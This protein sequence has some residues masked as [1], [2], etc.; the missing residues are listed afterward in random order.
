MIQS[1]QV[2]PQQQTVSPQIPSPQ[3]PVVRLVAGQRPQRSCHQVGICLNPMRSCTQH[4]EQVA[5]QQLQ[6]PT[7]EPTLAPYGV[8]GPYRRTRPSRADRLGL[9][10]WLLVWL[11]V[12][13]TALGVL[14][15]VEAQ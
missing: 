2:K 13:I 4:C 1:N 12:A 11:F 15:S 8:Q 5:L 6:R 14:V 3:I 7:T 10:V 9:A